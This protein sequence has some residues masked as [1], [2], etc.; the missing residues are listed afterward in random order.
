MYKPFV[1]EAVEAMDGADIADRVTQIRTVNKSK[2]DR[3]Y[4]SVKKKI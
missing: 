4:V 3:M 1:F 2:I